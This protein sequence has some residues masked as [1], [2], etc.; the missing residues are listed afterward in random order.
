MEFLSVHWHI[1]AQMKAPA[2]VSVPSV[3]VG[4]GEL[5]KETWRDHSMSVTAQADTV[6]LVRNRRLG[7][8]SEVVSPPDL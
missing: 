2:L 4:T 5:V 8:L 3:I 7:C 6:R 1:E